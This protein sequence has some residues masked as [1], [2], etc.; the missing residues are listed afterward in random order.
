VY[1]YVLAS[2]APASAAWWAGLL[3]AALVIGS[4]ALA[5]LGLERVR[6]VIARPSVAAREAA[7]GWATEPRHGY[8]RPFL[9]IETYIATMAGASAQPAERVTQRWSAEPPAPPP[10]RVLRPN[11]GEASRV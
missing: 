8:E 5:V 6:A 7:A 2:D 11:K 9:G 1:G 3:A 4:L 10:T